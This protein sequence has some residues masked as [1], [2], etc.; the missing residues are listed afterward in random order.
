VLSQRRIYFIA[1]NY[2]NSEYSIKYIE[3]VNRLITSDNSIKIIIV[4]NNSEIEDYSRLMNAVKNMNNLK[5]IRN[6]KNVGYFVGLNIGIRYAAVD[7]N[8]LCVIG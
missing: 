6:E 8:S 1:V 7:K 3:S 2:N 5:L 4:D